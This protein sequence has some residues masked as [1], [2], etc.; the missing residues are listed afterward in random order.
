MK[1]VTIAS[2]ILGLFLWWGIHQLNPIPQLFAPIVSVD[3]GQSRA[4]TALPI[5]RDG[6]RVEQDFFA[7]WD[8]LSQIELTIVR[9]NDVTDDEN[10]TLTL[11]LRDDTETAVAQETLPTHTFIHNSIHIFHFTPQ[12]S[13]GRYYT[14]Q[15]EGSPD[16]MLSVWG[17][18]VDTYSNGQLLTGDGEALQASDLRFTTRYTLTWIDALNAIGTKLLE[19]GLWLL[20]ALFFIPLPG[21]LLLQLVRLPRLPLAV[22]WGTA[23]ALGCAFWPVLWY[24]VGLVGVSLPKWLLWGVFGVGWVILAVLIY[25]NRFTTESA[26]NTERKHVKYEWFPLVGLLI[27]G[28]LVRLVAIRDLNTALWVDASRHGL[29]TAVMTHTATPIST[30]Q[31]YLPIDQFL[32]H[33]GFHTLSA[34]LQ[35]MWHGPLNQRLLLLGQLLNSLVPLVIYSSAWLFTRKHRVALLSAFLV[36]LP[37]FFPAYYATWGRFTQLTGM[38]ILPVLVGLLWRLLR[39][40]KGWQTA[41]GLIILLIMGLFLVHV[42]VFLIFVPFVPVVWL[43]SNGRYTLKLLST[44]LL[45]LILLA[46]RIWQLLNQEQSTN[47]ATSAGIAN[48]NEFPIGYLQAGWETQFAYLTGACV[49]IALVAA[50]F[51][52]RWASAPVT[53]IGWVSLL[54]F[55]L[56]G[57]RLGLPEL[58]LINLNSMY[59]T[60]FFPMAVLLGIVLVQI[61][62]WLTPLPRPL[63]GL[64]MALFG[65]LLALATLFGVRQQI[66]ILNERT[67]LTRP[68]D[69]NA[70][71]WLDDNLPDDAL[72]A[73]NSWKWLGNTWAA[74]DGGAWITPL[75]RKRTTTPPADYLYAP[76]LVEQVHGFNEAASGVDSW[77]SAEMAQFLRQQEVTHIFVGVQGGLFDPA[78]LVKNPDIGLLYAQD[79]TFVFEVLP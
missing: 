77:D 11:T 18:Q 40:A 33:Y 65:L 52:R 6:F 23:V 73:V 68:A 72:I 36:A 22:H 14:L 8:G 57:R 61:G 47:F 2:F 37:F 55:A 27:V 76:A 50:L 51:Q 78:Q 66:T 24:A 49:V 79:G 13:A 67:I 32:Y 3:I 31:P 74:S 42:R 53:L 38:L 10:A 60:L 39:G 69:I 75:T 45:T 62:R 17:Y 9:Y 44:T 43:I 54:F 34:S 41:W 29:I 35:S 5:L 16:N 56:S 48:Y 1:S 20:L 58:D 70:I 64:M 71:N 21:F 15:L 26:E 59:I 46:P 30:Y 25:K 12:P 63:I 28:F 4:D 19:D 7:H